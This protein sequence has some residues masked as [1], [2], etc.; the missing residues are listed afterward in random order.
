MTTNLELTELVI[1]ETVLAGGDSTNNFSEGFNSV[2][3]FESSHIFSLES[4]IFRV[5]LSIKVGSHDPIS[6][7]LT[8][9]VFVC[10]MEFVGVHSTQYC[11]QLFIS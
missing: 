11:I 3:I 2:V 8:L 7:Q 6:I 5:C 10:M 4:K 1:C 9:K